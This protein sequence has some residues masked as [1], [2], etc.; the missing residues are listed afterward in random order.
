MN[1]EPR[2]QWCCSKGCGSCDVKR[3]EFEYER[4]QDLEGNLLSSKTVPRLVSECCGATM[5]MW[6]NEREQD[7]DV[8][9]DNIADPYQLL[10]TATEDRR[11]RIGEACAEVF[12]WRDPDT[13]KTTAKPQAMEA[14]EAARA[15]GLKEQQ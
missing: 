3:I 4:T 11:D 12:G 5:F 1:A 15:L 2:F 9:V 7:I 14:A 13:G 6:D 10:P 8:D